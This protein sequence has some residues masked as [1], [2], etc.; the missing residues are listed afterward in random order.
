MYVTQE[1]VLTGILEYIKHEVFPE[2]PSYAKVLAGAALLH[3]S[4]RLSQILQ[5]LAEGSAMKALDVV[6][7]EGSIDV[8][9]WCYQLKNAMNQFCDGKVEI[10][11]PGLAPMIFRENDIDKLKNY[12]R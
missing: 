9:E 6:S 4:S 11:L 10:K 2:M 5:D 7:D 12:M 3:N 8:D 1:K